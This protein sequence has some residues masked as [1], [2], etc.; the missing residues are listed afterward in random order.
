MFIKEMSGLVRFYL[1]E[2]FT[3]LREQIEEET[4]ESELTMA[5]KPL[6]A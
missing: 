4:K 6:K 3:V 5:W 2:G 1:R